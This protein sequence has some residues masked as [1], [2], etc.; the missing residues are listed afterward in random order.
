MRLIVPK[1]ALALAVALL[2]VAC[3][4]YTRA[5]L[6]G[7]VQHDPSLPRVVLLGDSI[8]VQS[9]TQWQNEMAAE[10]SWWSHVLATGG[11]TIADVMAADDD[12]LDPVP[13]APDAVIANIGTNDTFDCGLSPTCGPSWVATELDDLWAPY[14]VAGVPCR[15]AVTIRYET[16][17]GLVTSINDRIS[18][19]HGTGVITHVADWK[20]HSAGHPEW[21]KDSIGHP[22]TAGK[23][24]LAEFLTDEL[25]EACPA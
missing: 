23:L 7:V 1:L 22:T 25:Q 9:R 8:T 15:V 13:F 12:V 21:F 11:W 4:P 16:G 19:L 3:V 2:A 14:V 6:P 24:A 18:H 20:A 10:T 5:D 17:S